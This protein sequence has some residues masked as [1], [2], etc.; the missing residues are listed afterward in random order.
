VHTVL[1]AWEQDLHL[2]LRPDD[3]WL[4]ILTQLS[5]FVNARAEELRH[6]F[7]AH[8]GKKQV[9][10]VVD[11]PLDKLDVPAMAQA[12]VRVL[13]AQIVDEGMVE[14]MMPGFSTTT[15]DDKAVAAVAV[16]GTM[17][18]YFHY[19]AIQGCGFPSVTLEGERS[20][21][22]DLQRRVAR[23][24]HFGDEAAEW[25]RCLGKVVEGMVASFDR[26]EDEQVKEFWMKASHS[27]GADG[28][29]EPRTLSGWLTAFCWWT[30]EGKKQ[31]M[32]DDEELSDWWCLGQQAAWV[33]LELDGVV[34]PVINRE[35]PAAVTR[36]P[37]TW[38]DSGSGADIATVLLAGLTGMKLMDDTGSKVRPASG[39][40]I[41]KGD[42]VSGGR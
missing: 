23:L 17:R 41:L 19:G 20:D 32:Y 16:L 35:I 36:A 26:P 40:W 2:T 31:R 12:L 34:F 8:Q 21:W 39:W 3:V 42:P 13:Q 25:A 27:A 6:F 10:V 14:W 28:S 30:A 37:M 15:E 9:T 38:V 4:A 11:D 5:F 22:E 7:V 33:R 24:A 18:Q 29:G 1:R